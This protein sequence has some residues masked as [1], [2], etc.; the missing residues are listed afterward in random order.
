MELELPKVQKMIKAFVSTL[1]TSTHTCHKHIVLTQ[2]TY[3]YQ[4]DGRM[5]GRGRE[6]GV[7]ER[8]S[9]RVYK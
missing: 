6:M 2:S 3:E 7:T 4:G 5:G 8:S 1:T 9:K